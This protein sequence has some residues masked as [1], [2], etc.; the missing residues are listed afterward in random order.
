MP[1]T[2]KYIPLHIEKMI[3][4]SMRL[5]TR[6]ASAELEEIEIPTLPPL[7][8]EEEEAL[9]VV[10]DVSAKMRVKLCQLKSF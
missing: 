4:A 9:P 2:W 8:A 7:N 6:I 10:R 5:L 3:S 1:L